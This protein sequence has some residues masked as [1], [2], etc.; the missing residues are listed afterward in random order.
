M[1][2]E[3]SVDDMEIP[4]PE[5]P[6][7]S[8]SDWSPCSV[9]CGKGVKIRTRLLL[10]LP[11]M[12]EICKRKIELNQQ[13]ACAE[14]ADCTFDMETAKEVCSMT[15]DPGSCRGQY[16]RYAYSVGTESC[17]PFTYTGCRGNLNNFLT[18]EDCMQSCK[19]VRPAPSTE[20]PRIQQVDNTPVDCVLSEWT[21]WTPCSVT[22]GTGR[23]EKFRNILVEDKNGGIPCPKRN[24][25]KRKCSGP[26][27]AY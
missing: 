9:T 6:V 24:I 21:E 15:A 17:V 22:C 10:V 8:W 2:P 1:R 7:S 20:A 27:C 25:K 16:M 4:D 19:M 26:P 3:C 13:K 12:Q 14:K 5:C 11:E 18:L 23:S